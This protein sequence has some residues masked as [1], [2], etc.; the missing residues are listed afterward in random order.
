VIRAEVTCPGTWLA[1]ERMI[2][3]NVWFSFK[4]GAAEE[5]ELRKMTHFLGDLKSRTL[6]HDYKL[7]R[8]RSVET[9]LAPFHAMISFLD[10]DQFGR[11]F[12]EVSNTG[13]HSGPHGLMIENVD[14]F[15]VE[16]FEELT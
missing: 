7:L 15:I 14:I 4:A 3:Y 6:I 16:I 12:N 13:V 1:S 8:N 10:D 11:P 2:H 5:D 9:K